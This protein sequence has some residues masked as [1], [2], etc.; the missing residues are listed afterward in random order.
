M[1]ERSAQKK[2]PLVNLERTELALLPELKRAAGQV[3]ESFSFIGGEHVA[4]FEQQACRA[5]RAE[6]AVGVSSGTDALTA[7]LMA[8]GIGPDDEVI[9][10]PF[11]F[12][13]TAG[14]IARL[15][16]E[17][18]F[19]DIEPGTFNLDAALIEAAI[20]P[21]TRAIVPVHLFGQMCD[22]RAINAIALKHGLHVIEDAAQAI[23][24]ERDGLR[25]GSVGELG[26]LSFFPT[27]NLGAAGDAG[28]VTC[29]DRALAERVRLICRHGAHP[30]Y[31][32]RVI[33]ANFRLDAIQASLLSVKLPHLDDW[34]AS[35]ARN[36]AYYDA[37]LPAHV[38]APAL[39]P[40]VT[41]H[42][43]HHYCV[44]TPDRDRLRE[45]MG[46]AGVQ[47]GVYYPRPL[48]LQGCFAELGYAEG[49]LPHAERACHEIMALPVWPGMREEEL[50]RV[51]EAMG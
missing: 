49:D 43:Y 33:G 16:A 51:I 18:V 3:L 31:V 45:A 44:R 47:T 17:P 9:T 26:C 12:F 25:A 48:H 32:H 29:R 41:R 46:A 2:V 11:T 13:A 40:G 6:H 30:K 20:T 50:Q 10:T 15:G 22:M 24:A 19:V 35:R 42:V 14:S 5:L 37:H 23:L 4:R 28:L 21:N 1:S 7:A 34:T 39:A 8:C 27:K 38:S 36:A